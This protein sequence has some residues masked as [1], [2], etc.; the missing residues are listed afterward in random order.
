M[1]DTRHGFGHSDKRQG[2]CFAVIL[3]TLTQI[4]THHRSK[5]TNLLVDKQDC[6]N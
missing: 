3:L 1:A 5:E 2:I 6:L 4:V